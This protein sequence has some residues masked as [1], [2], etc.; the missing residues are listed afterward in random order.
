MQY[1]A[2]ERAAIRE[3]DASCPAEKAGQ[4]AAADMLDR[5]GRQEIHERLQAQGSIKSLQDKWHSIGVQ[6]RAENEPGRKDKLFSEWMVLAAQIN[7]L[8]RESKNGN[9]RRISD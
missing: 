8:K 3:V 1:E 2:D 4:L 9:D 7:E 5:K 6:M